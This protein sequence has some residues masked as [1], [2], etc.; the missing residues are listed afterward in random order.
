MADKQTDK[1]V[2]FTNSNF[3]ELYISNS[4]SSWSM[5]SRF[6]GSMPGR[7][8]VLVSDK[9]CFNWVELAYWHKQTICIHI[10]FQLLTVHS[11]IHWWCDDDHGLDLIWFE[12]DNFWLVYF[13][14]NNKRPSILIAAPIWEIIGGWAWV[15]MFER[16]TS[17]SHF[18]GL[19]WR[20]LDVYN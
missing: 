12:W 9:Q 1:D 15:S 11:F 19:I 5:A 10:S 6:D 7:A 18:G 13:C 2:L 14:N 4:I 20:R 16:T 3:I 17:S 8:R